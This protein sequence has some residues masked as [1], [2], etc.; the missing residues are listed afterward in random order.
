[1]VKIEN[2]IISF[3]SK[4]FIIAEVGVNHNGSLKLCF[5]LIDAAIEAGAD[6]VKFQT[7]KTESLV[8][9][10]AEKAIYQKR[11]SGARESQYEMLKKL[12]LSPEDHVAIKE[13]CEKKGII[14]LST[15]FD[16]ESVD[17]LERI[18]I[19]AYKISSGDLT[20]L[21]F[22]QYVAKREK[23][24]LISSGMS[25][26]GEIEEA[27]QTI[28]NTGNEHIVLLHCTSN[29]PTA[30]RDVN[31]KAINTLATAF[32]IP[33][34]YSDHTPGIEVPVAAVALGAKALE[35]HLTLDRNLPGPDHKASLEPGEFRAMVTSVRH[36]EEALGDGIKRSFSCEEDVKKAARKSIVARIDI[37]RGV[38]VTADM[39]AL[40]RPGDGLP[41]KLLEFVIGKKTK[42]EIKKDSLINFV[43]LT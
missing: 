31:L 21:P 25:G 6:A 38:T 30:Y 23:P 34:G 36:I 32:Q 9:V 22:L 13:Y 10:N 35:K 17:L 14:F 3:N 29:Y 33:V 12:E 37:P 43:D 8:T 26:L 28:R 24:I 5:D 18:N 15:P 40:K 19:P 27:L 2:K 7:F 1:M 39:L 16:F 41:P 20:N 11:N 42:I 4:A